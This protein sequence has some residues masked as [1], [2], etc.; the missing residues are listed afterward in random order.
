MSR[1]SRSRR[2]RLLRDRRRGRVDLD[3]PVREPL[4]VPDHG[5]ERRLQLVT[6]G[7]Q[8][9]A[10]G[11]AGVLELVRH[12]VERL[13]ERRE[14][15]RAL[16]R[17]GAR[18]DTCREALARLD[19][20]TERPRDSSCEQERDRGRERDADARRDQQPFQVR[21]PGC[22]ADNSRAQQHERLSGNRP[23]RV[24][25]FLPVD[26]KRSVAAARRAGREELRR[27][28]ERRDDDAF[29]LA[30]E[31]RS[32]RFEMPERQE[33]L[34]LALGEQISLLR[35]VLQDRTVDRA[36]RQHGA[37]GER[38]RRGEEHDD[39][40]RSEQLRAQAARTQLHS[41]AAL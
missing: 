18:C 13:G 25:P 14:L 8:E 30:R 4:R 22:G 34:A 17:D 37:D 1:T 5:G 10:L 29:V 39:A 41:R 33:R 31:E 35:D 6:D 16:G 11:V 21:T 28:A 7:E 26:R 24:E 20:A 2:A 19:D 40:D 12:V 36:A 27:P 15:G 38:D 3:R 9:R 32:H 23:G